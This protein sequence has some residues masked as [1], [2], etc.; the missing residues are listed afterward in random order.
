M[1]LVEV[2]N[3]HM[4]NSHMHTSLDLKVYMVLKYFY[5]KWTTV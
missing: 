4:D 3:S 1:S 5:Y 2:N